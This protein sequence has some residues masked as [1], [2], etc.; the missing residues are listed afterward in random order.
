MNKNTKRSF[1][2]DALEQAQTVF[3]GWKDLGDRLVVPNMSLDDFEKRLKKTHEKVALVEKV[4]LERS[5]SVE[6]RNQALEDV[7]DL[8]KRIRNSA[9]ATFGDDSEEVEKFGGR[10]V[11]FRKLKKK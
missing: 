1:P 9:K 5:D 2:R 8:I 4:R 7:W 6:I 3:S 11:R 10:A